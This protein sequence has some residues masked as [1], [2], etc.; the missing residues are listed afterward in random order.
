MLTTDIIQISWDTV[1][2]AFPHNLLLLQEKCTG[3]N[4]PLMMGEFC[5]HIAIKWRKLENECMHDV[6]GKCAG[7]H[8]QKLTLSLFWVSVKWLLVRPVLSWGDDPICAVLLL[9]VPSSLWSSG[10]ITSPLPIDETPQDTTLGAPLL[11]F[12]PR[13]YGLCGTDRVSGG[14]LLEPLW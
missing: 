3:S 12:R 11:R 9:L 4:E 5:M 1:Q 8:T 14:L 10:R 2:W 13:L 6:T 7:K